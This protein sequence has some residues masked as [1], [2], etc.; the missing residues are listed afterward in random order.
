MNIPHT[1]FRFEGDLGEFE[2]ILLSVYLF[3]PV[4]H[5]VSFHLGSLRLSTED[6][7]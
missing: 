5:L 1:Y 3:Y 6:D 7:A 4:A 2:Y